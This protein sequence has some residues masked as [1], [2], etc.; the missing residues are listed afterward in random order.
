MAEI[1][2]FAAFRYDPALVELEKVVT[3]PYDKITPEM[4]QRYE[5]LSPYNLI[6][7]EKG[8]SL[9]GDTP[10]ENVYTRAGETLEE[11]MARGILVRDPSP[12]VY[13]YSQD[14]TVPGTG[15]RRVRRGF[16]GLGRLEDYSSGVVFRHEQTHAAPKADRLEL[17]RR[18]RVQTGL[19]LMLYS[20]AGRGID[21]R[22]AAVAEAR[23][24]AVVR[25]EFGVVHRLWRV[26]E[27][28]LVRELVSLMAEQKLIIADGH[29]RYETALA[30]RDE[31]RAAASGKIDPCAPHEKAMMA[32]FNTYSSLTILPTHR[33]VRGLAAF[34]F[35]PFRKQLAAHFDW[36]AYP[37][38]D[39][40]ERA[41]SLAEF[42]KDLAGRGRG[43]PALGLYPGGGAFY[44]F[45]LRRDA[46]LSS[47]LPDVPPVV[48]QLDVVLLHRIILG[49]ALGIAP[50]AVRAG[51]FIGYER[52]ME[53]ALAAVDD[54]RAQLACLLNPVRIE[55]VREIALAG[56]VLPQ[57]STDFYPKLL[58]GLC[59]YRLDG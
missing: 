47:L 9:P 36:Y 11:W 20:D 14:Y 39:P 59:L 3:Q 38:S 13:V 1:F 48:R 49:R 5:S 28:S 57:K 10:G 33:V 50:E 56:E 32:F 7:V 42:R 21:A 2:P 34:R 17:L 37:F 18:T 35:E 58:S 4:Q 25:D 16:I 43:R 40:E 54:G 31:R 41:R 15:D 53:A 55:Q 19:L 26:A 45:L 12:G 27:D 6:P 44:L 24:D 30:Y 23:P 8:R 29:H 46:S 22:L 51:Q 52:E